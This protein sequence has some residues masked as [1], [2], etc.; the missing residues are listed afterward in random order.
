MAV[1]FVFFVG[2][3]CQSGSVGCN[4][5]SECSDDLVCESGAVG[6]VT[7]SNGDDTTGCVV[8]DVVVWVGVGD[9]D[10]V[11]CRGVPFDVYSWKKV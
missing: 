4:G 8:Y 1:L 10:L 5:F 9:V 2:E 6:S 7:P 3:V 11:L